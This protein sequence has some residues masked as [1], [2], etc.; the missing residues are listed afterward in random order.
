[1]QL[2]IF[3][4]DEELKSLRGLGAP[5]DLSPFYNPGASIMHAC[6]AHKSEEILF[7]DSNAQARIFSLVTLRPEPASLLSKMKAES[8]Q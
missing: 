2:H 6:S 4:F 7:V 5:I 3:V 8:V 1:M